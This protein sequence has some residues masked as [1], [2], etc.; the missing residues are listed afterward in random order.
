MFGS[1]RQY[2][3]SMNKEW[4]LF[5]IFDMAPTLMVKRSLTEGNVYKNGYECE[6]THSAYFQFY[7]YENIQRKYFLLAV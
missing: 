7:D 3:D 5:E 2:L 1:K 4:D 6:P